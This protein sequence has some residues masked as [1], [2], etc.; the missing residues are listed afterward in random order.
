MRRTF[1]VVTALP[2]ST[3]FLPQRGVANPLGASRHLQLPL[4]VWC[5]CGSPLKIG[6]PF[7]KMS[8]TAPKGKKK[9]AGSSVTQAPTRQQAAALAAP[10]RTPAYP[11]LGG[12]GGGE[13]SFVADDDYYQAPAPPVGPSQVC[14]LGLDFGQWL[15]VPA[16]VH[17]HRTG[18]TPST[19]AY[20]A[21]H[22]AVAAMRTTRVCHLMPC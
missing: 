8:R 9:G 12:G 16:H 11:T 3:S 4:S 20:Q 19:I 5:A 21:L 14:W 6:S 13:A 15:G 2:T 1:F 17:T 10:V 7:L 22:C 18:E